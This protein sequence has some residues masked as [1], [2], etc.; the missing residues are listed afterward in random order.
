MEIK[1]TM[2]GL[3]IYQAIG[4][5]LLALFVAAL[6]FRRL[7][8]ATYGLGFIAAVLALI[9]RG[10]QVHHFPLQN[11]FEIF[12]FLGAMVFPA[13]LLSRKL[14]KTNDYISDIVLGIILL[15]PAGFVFSARPQQ[16]PPA[17]QSILFVPH[18]LVY[19]L[20]YVTMTKAAILAGKQ[21][22]SGGEHETSAY[23]LVCIGFPLLTLGL[24]LGSVWGKLA[25]G[26]YW[27]WDPKEMWS[28]ATWL[29]YVGYFHFRVQ[30]IRYKKINAVWLIAGFVFIVITLSWVNLSR[31]FAGLHNYA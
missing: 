25:W 3:L 23:K 1:Y 27:H 6:K 31:I 19:M 5:Y 22:V 13:T 10:I 28:L 29:V 8:W 7:S 4:F 2:Q 17:L 21:L 26:D 18:V 9:Y 16:L 12:L 30:F 11:L 24:I 20:A 15:I 14:L